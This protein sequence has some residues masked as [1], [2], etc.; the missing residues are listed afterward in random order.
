M[1]PGR[2]C[3]S[4]HRREEGRDIVRIGGTVYPTVREPDLCLGVDGEARPTE[5]V[6]TDATGQVLR[7]PVGPT[8]NF[9]LR[10]SGAR[11]EFPIRAKV[12]HEGRERAMGT[13]QTSGD[14]N[15]CHT[16]TGAN[17]APGR[18]YLP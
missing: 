9:S 13:P 7:L 15:G 12:V 6:I 3:I 14:C 2:A 17:G 1:N 4:C 8:G 11:I 16:E 5:V 10:T 18:I